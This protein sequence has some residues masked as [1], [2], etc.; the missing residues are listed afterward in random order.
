M[1]LSRSLHWFSWYSKWIVMSIISYIF[2]TL[3]LCVPIIGKEAIFQKSNFFLIWLFFFFYCSSIITFCF[4]VSVLFQKAPS[5]NGVGTTL[6]FVTYVPYYVYG[7]SFETLN[8]IVKWLICLPVNSSMGVVISIVLNMEANQVGL[9]FSNMFTHIAGFGFSFGEV[10]FCLVLSTMIHVL[11]T[12]YIEMVFPGEV[13]VPK[14]WYFPIQSCL[15]LIRKDKDEN[16]AR[17]SLGSFDAKTGVTSDNFEEDPKHLNAT[18][19]LENLTKFFGPNKA[20]DGLSLNMYEDQITVLCGHNGA[21]KTT[22]MNMLIGMLPPSSGTAFINGFDITTELK[23]ARKSIGICP[24]AN[25]LFNDLTVRE[26]I[27]FFCKLKGMKDGKKIDQEVQKY[28]DMLGL[29]D[30]MN[31]RSKS[32]S[33]GQK[34]RLSIVNALCGQSSFVILDEVNFKFKIF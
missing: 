7:N 8:Y 23:E 32:L 2:V 27:I 3:F 6:F 15:K 28:V 1:G 29:K 5:V 20:V 13:G 34:R 19:K 4:L 14:P 16:N 24:Q 10:L 25:I 30:K 22:A 18:V 12:V 9:D 11:I 33:G 26:H 21:G 31:S 17:Y